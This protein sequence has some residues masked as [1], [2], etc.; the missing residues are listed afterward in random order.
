M[1]DASP[2]DQ[3][4]DAAIQLVLLASRSPADAMRALCRRAGDEVAKL[5]GE[6]QAAMLCARRARIHQERAGN[7]LRGRR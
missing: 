1:T 7:M 2:L 4:A 3:L 6:E 5:E